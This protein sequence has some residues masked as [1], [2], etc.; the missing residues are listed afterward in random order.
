MWDDWKDEDLKVGADYIIANSTQFL[1][2]QQWLHLVHLN[3][4]Y[5]YSRMQANQVGDMALGQQ[6]G[7]MRIKFKYVACGDVNVM[8]QQMQNEHGRYTFR[9][10]NPTK[11]DTPWGENND[12]DTDASCP[13]FCVCCYFVEK[14]MK[15]AF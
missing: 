15:E 9:Q 1:N 11:I 7:D 10:W 8:A 2:S 6:I 3:D 12:S 4:G 14:F 13:I 5:L